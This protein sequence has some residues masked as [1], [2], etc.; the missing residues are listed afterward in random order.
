MG[1]RRRHISDAVLRLLVKQFGAAPGH[2]ASHARHHRRRRRRRRRGHCDGEKDKL[3]QSPL[4][5]KGKLCYLLELSR[6]SVSRATSR[7][8]RTKLVQLVAVSAAACA[9][10]L[11]RPFVAP[12]Y[13]RLS[14]TSIDSTLPAANPLKHCICICKSAHPRAYIRPPPSPSPSSPIAA[15]TRC[16]RLSRSSLHP[17]SAD[18]PLTLRPQ[19]RHR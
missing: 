9:R 6:L 13:T 17:T 16:P 14:S 19:H 10:T 2:G 8:P 18:L 4:L 7:L 11:I 15:I 5:V 12:C 1:Y 3:T